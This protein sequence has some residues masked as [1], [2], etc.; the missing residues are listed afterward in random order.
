[1]SR[2]IWI[3]AG[4]CVLVWAATGITLIAPFE[5]GVV[6][7]WGRL[8]KPLSPGPHWLAPWGIDRLD[9]VAVDRVRTTRIGLVPEDDGLVP[10]GQLVTGDHNLIQVDLAAQWRVDPARV[11]DF[12]LISDR[13][14][15]ILAQVVEGLLGEWIGERAIDPLLL[16]GKVRLPGELVPKAQERLERLGMGLILT[17]L[18]AAQL[19]PPEEV[20]GA[21][22]LVA[23]AEAGRQ[24]LVTR[25]RQ[26]SETRGRAA[27]AETYRIQQESRT[28]ADNLSRL[29]REEANRFLLRLEGYAN[30][31]KSPIFLR[32]IWEEERGRLFARLREVG[33]I[34]MLDHQLSGKGLDL[35]V[36]PLAPIAPRR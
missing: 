29:A 26:E 11:T 6:R 34:G 5:R 35:Q 2:T 20:R 25:V 4:L 27:Q 36:A 31:G 17:D 13:A 19:S 18:R 14:E 33:G 9:R 32:Q 16:E 7:R 10:R 8:L 3:A 23:R 21:F 22:D 12:A 24:T 1:M 28:R 15:T 30:G